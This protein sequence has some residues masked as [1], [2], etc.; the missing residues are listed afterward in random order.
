M[1]FCDA[2][3]KA[4]WL[5]HECRNVPMVPVQHRWEAA[6]SVLPGWREQLAVQLG[7]LYKGRSG[8]SSFIGK[9]FCGLSWLFDSGKP[10]YV[11]D[12]HRH[13]YQGFSDA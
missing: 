3:T 8:V 10:A 12:K 13:S 2:T 5:E 1:T 9:I 7:S 11:A 6:C 4:A